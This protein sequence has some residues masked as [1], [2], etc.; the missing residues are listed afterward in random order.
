VRVVGTVRCHAEAHAGC[1]VS[2]PGAF[3]VIASARGTG[4]HGMLEVDYDAAV[5][6]WAAC[7]TRPFPDDAVVIKADWRRVLPD[8]PLPVYDTSAAGLAR[9]L[10]P[11]GG[12]AWGDG[13]ATADPGPDDIYTATLANGNTYRLAAM[14]IMTKELDHW[15]WVTLWWSATP[16][17]DFGADRPAGVTGPWR[18]YKMCTTTA[19]EEHDPEADGGFGGSLGAALAVVHSPV[20]WCSN[21]YLERGSGNADTNCVGCHQHGGTGLQVEAILADPTLFPAHGRTVV[22]NNFPSD[23]SWTVDHGDELTRLFADVIEYY[24]SAPP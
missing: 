22:R 13:D 16:D 1:T 24:D 4:A 20:S 21:P 12:F 19:F 5:P 8:M 15:V 3:D 6:T 2:G 7:L 9:R 14:H 18:H 23:Y 10:G 11:N 17:D